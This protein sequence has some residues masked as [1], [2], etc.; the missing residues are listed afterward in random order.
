[1]PEPGLNSAL[2]QH[3]SSEGTGGFEGRSPREEYRRMKTAHVGAGLA[4]PWAISYR[5][6]G[7]WDVPPEVSNQPI[8]SAPLAKMLD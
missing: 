2:R 6:V 8:I 1:M 4:L 3:N 5:A 7:A